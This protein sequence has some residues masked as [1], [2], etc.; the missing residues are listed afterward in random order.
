MS[1]G[2]GVRF[3]GGRGGLGGATGDLGGSGGSPTSGMV[4][5]GTLGTTA[6]GLGGFVGRTGSDTEEGTWLRAERGADAVRLGSAF[7][8]MLSGREE[9]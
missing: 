1:G 2:G 7:A 9:A 6:A 4:S 3:S 8:G 5:V